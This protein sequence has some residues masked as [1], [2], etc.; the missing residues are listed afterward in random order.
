[1]NGYF[2]AVLS[3]RVTHRCPSR[4]YPRRRQL[5]K[6]VLALMAW[7]ALHLDRDQRQAWRA[8]DAVALET[9]QSF[10]LR[11]LRY[12]RAPRKTG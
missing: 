4:L 5:T 10:D 2:N 6:R 12:S 11:T 8:L 1:M 3:R 9:L 7:L